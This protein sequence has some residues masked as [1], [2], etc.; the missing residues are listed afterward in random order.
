MTTARKQRTESALEPDGEITVTRFKGNVV[1][2]PRAEKR[3]SPASGTAEPAASDAALDVLVDGRRVIVE[4]AREVVLRCGKA[5]ITLTRS[6]KIIL[7]GTHVVSRSS[8]SNR[9]QG[10]TV[11]IN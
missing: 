5:S 8:G 7:R 11:R 9:V 4:G 10:S 3:A 6:G 1:S 2:L